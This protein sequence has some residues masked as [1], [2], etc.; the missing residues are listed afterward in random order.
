MFYRLYYLHQ[1][2]L[3]GYVEE[4]NL[5]STLYRSSP[6]VAAILNA[7]NVTENFVLHTESPFLSFYSYCAKT[8]FHSQHVKDLVIMKLIILIISLSLFLEL[9]AYI[10]IFIKQTKI[11]SQATVYE[12]R[13]GRLVSRQ[14]HQRNVVSVFGHF[15][16]FIISIIQSLGLFTGFYFLSGSD[17]TAAMIRDLTA[18]FIPSY[19]FCIYPVIEMLLSENLRESLLSMSWWPI[20]FLLTTFH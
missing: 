5:V 9:L 14:R 7:L 13:G 20:I 15:V 6:V 1:G 17:E 18:F 16:N 8:P 10:A 3:S 4:D 11:E 19:L 2:W 12:V